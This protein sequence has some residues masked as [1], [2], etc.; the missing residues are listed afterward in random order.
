MTTSRPL[1][2]SFLYKIWL[3]HEDDAW[4]FLA[5]RRGDRWYQI[6]IQKDGNLRKSIKSFFKSYPA[7]EYDL[8]FC[9]NA[10]GSPSR[11]KTEAIKTPYAWCDIDEADPYQFKPP[12]GV[13]WKSSPGRYQGLWRFNRRLHQKR[14]ERISRYLAYEFGA[15]KSGWEINKYLRI[16]GTYNHKRSGKPPR[17]K[18]L[19]FEL[20]KIDPAPLLKVAP[21]FQPAKATT[22]D[23]DVSDFDLNRDPVALFNKYRRDIRH[24]KAKYLLRHK[25]AREQDR[26]R[27]IFIIITALAS[28]GVPWRDIA[29]L[30]WHSPYFREKHGTDITALEAEIRRGMNKFERED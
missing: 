4:L 11:K 25:T 23:V 3:C 13:L 6:S 9:P 17:V 30:V 7:L 26:S 12:P 1:R 27:Q 8:Y 15:D 28:A 29:C 18:L 10:F 20:S 16:P 19:D 14:G 22:E 21:K 24:R 2:T 5:A